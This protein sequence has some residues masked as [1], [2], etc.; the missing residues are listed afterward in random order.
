M[1]SYCRNIDRV[2]VKGSDKP[3]KIYT[4][5]MNYERITPPMNKALKYHNLSD[6]PDSEAK[7]SLN[8]EYLKE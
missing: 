2:T 3:L 6:M 4:V 5:D 8:M 7:R 1:Q